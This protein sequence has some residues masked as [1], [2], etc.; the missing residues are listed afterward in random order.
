MYDELWTQILHMG[1]PHQRRR[2]R[3]GAKQGCPMSGI[4][5]ALGTDPSVR[6][7]WRRFAGD[8]RRDAQTRPSG[9][10][11]ADSPTIAVV[12]RNMA[13]SMSA[14]L[15]L[16]R[17][18]GGQRAGTQAEQVCSDRGEQRFGL[19]QPGDGGGR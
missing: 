11:G 18:R 5:Y 15:G 13:E 2:I 10:L 1:C 4:L 3:R 14:L 8:R 9:L 6:A 16:L 19:V 7:T 12:M 17:R